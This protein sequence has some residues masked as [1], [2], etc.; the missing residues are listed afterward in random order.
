[1]ERYVKGKKLGQGGFGA[2]FLVTHRDSGKQ[3]VLKEIQ[4]ADARAAADAKKEAAFLRQ[5]QHPNIVSYAESFQV[6]A[7]GGGSTLCIIMEFADGGDLAQRVAAAKRRGAPPIPEAEALGYFLQICLALRHVHGKRI[8]HRDLKSQ[9]VFLTK[10]GIV[11]VGDFGI[12]KTLS[13]SLD[14]AKTQ[15]RTPARPLSRGGR[16]PRLLA[17][18]LPSFSP[19]RSARRTTS[20]PRSAATGR[21]TRRATCGRWV[22][23]CLSCLRWRCPSPR[24][25]CRSW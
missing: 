10:A 4:L 16:C 11:K 25:T 1:M 8:L 14:M 7:P 13:S 2:A 24:P 22:S 5:L 23:S 20:A 18:E 3:Y 15:V 12:A 9:N 19:P 6:P 21:T 17:R